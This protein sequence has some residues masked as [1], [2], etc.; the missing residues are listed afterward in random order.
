MCRAV[1]CVFFPYQKLAFRGEQEA[2]LH[3]SLQAF[4]SRPKDSGYE[5][6]WEGVLKRGCMRT[7]ILPVCT[8]HH[9]GH[10]DC[11]ELS[12]NSKILRQKFTYI[13]LAINLRAT[14]M[15]AISFCLQ[16]KN[17]RRKEN[18]YFL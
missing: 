8:C 9:S 3:Q 13:L 11:Q 12:G 7:Q 17:G 15:A 10:V 16:T 2:I 6:E 1:V 18:V 5:I 14:N 4:C